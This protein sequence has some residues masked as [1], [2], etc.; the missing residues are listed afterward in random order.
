MTE[1][2]P[3]T[4]SHLAAG[5]PRP[6]LRGVVHQYAFFFS[7]PVGVA[8]VV[9]APTLRAAS[10]AA[11]YAAAVSALLGVSALYHRVIW[12]PIARRRMRQL[13]H[14]MILVL[15]AASYT[16]FALLI[17]H[18]AL[19][20]VILAAMWGAALLG[21]AVNLLWIDVPK[22][23]TAAAYAAVGLL[24]VPIVPQL[25]ERLGPLG[26]SLILLA[27]A[28][29]AAGGAT[30]ALRRPNP[31][32][33]VFAY[34]EVFHALIVAAVATLYLAM[35]LCAL[36]AAGGRS[37]TYSAD[38]P[39]LRLGGATVVSIPRVQDGGVSQSSLRTPHVRRDLE[40][41][42]AAEQSS[43]GRSPGR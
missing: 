37:A 6:R 42:P 38:E 20:Q 39:S 26:I 36:P 2:T 1:L 23:L 13:D 14:S 25:I 5:Q 22:P 35:A 21:T 40:G 30:Y 19:A 12:S 4:D 33:G 8:L 3:S 11:I 34:H 28:L 32:P 24:S 10:A 16:A 18:G 27:G 9:S 31:W 29:S 43:A 17:L 41:A 15:I 7:L